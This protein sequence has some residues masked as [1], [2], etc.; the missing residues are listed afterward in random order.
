MPSARPGTVASVPART[1][2]SCGPCPLVATIK[3]GS[4]TVLFQGTA[5]STPLRTTGLLSRRHNAPLRRLL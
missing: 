5:T 4:M 2:N 1:A 3:D